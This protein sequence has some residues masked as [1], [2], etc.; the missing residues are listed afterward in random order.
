M[1]ACVVRAMTVRGGAS[2]VRI[3]RYSATGSR[4]PLT[5]DSSCGRGERGRGIGLHLSESAAPVG[6]GPGCRAPRRRGGGAGTPWGR[7][8]RGVRR[9]PL[10]HDR[11]HGVGE[12]RDDRRPEHRKVP[13][14]LGRRAGRVAARGGAARHGMRMRAAMREAA[15]PVPSS[16]SHDAVG[17]GSPAAARLMPWTGGG[18][19]GQGPAA[20]AGAAKGAADMGVRVPHHAC[21]AAPLPEPLS[22]MRRIPLTTPSAPR[23]SSIVFLMDG[24]RYTALQ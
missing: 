17:A 23:A 16:R 14:A 19:E 4:I 12:D 1:H 24:S 13:R 2:R 5:P 15:I 21:A 20:R 3:V 10:A 11:R 7:G 6:G 9:E 18:G 8:L 22:S